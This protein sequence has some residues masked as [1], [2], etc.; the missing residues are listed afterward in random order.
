MAWCQFWCQ[1][2]LSGCAVRQSRGLLNRYTGSNLY[3]GFESPPLR[4]V[5]IG[6]SA[7]YTEQL[8][9]LEKF[10]GEHP[11]APYARFLLGYH[12]GFLGHSK[13]ARTEL[14]QA[15][16][17]EEPDE[18]A[19]RLLAHFGGEAPHTK[20]GGGQAA[21]DRGRPTRGSDRDAERM[22]RRERGEDGEIRRE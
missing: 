7:Y 9:R 12:Y 3:P 16:K 8:R 20:S 6:T 1:L 18:L 19:G 15:V 22:T 10:V 14:A 17:L 21:E 11:D 4:F 5:P 2:V 13:Q